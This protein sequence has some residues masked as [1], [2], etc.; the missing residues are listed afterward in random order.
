VEVRSS[1]GLGRCEPI[2]DRQCMCV[3]LKWTLLRQAP[4]EFVFLLHVRES[5][6]QRVWATRCFKFDLDSDITVRSVDAF[7]RV[8]CRKIVRLNF[9]HLSRDMPAMTRL[10]DKPRGSLL[11]REPDNIEREGESGF[12][13]H[14]VSSCSCF[15]YAKARTNVCGPPVASSSIS[16]RT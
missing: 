3:F 14:R 6:N 2:A 10:V 7:K 8:Q 9:E 13:R 12:D 4:C 11:V 5:A 16:T 1:E 15:M